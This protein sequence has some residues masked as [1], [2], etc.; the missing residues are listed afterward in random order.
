MTR[1]VRQ[2]TALTVLCL[3]SVVVAVASS[4]DDYIKD[5]KSDNP[6]VRA[7]AAYELGCT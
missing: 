2:L 4:V 5:L 6:D 7:K 1:I 3:L